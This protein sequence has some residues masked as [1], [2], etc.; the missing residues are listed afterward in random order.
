MSPMLKW[1][2]IVAALG[3]MLMIA[4]YR[5]A[6]KKKEGFTKG[7]RTRI[8]GLFWLTCFASAGVASLIWVAQDL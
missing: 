5:L 3:I 8:V 2:L 7:D 6:T 4:D 1:A